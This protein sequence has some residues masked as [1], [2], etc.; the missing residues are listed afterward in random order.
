LEALNHGLQIVTTRYCGEVVKE[1]QSGVL[2]RDVSP[3]EIARAVTAYLENPERLA[4]ARQPTSAM[5]RFSLKSIGKQLLGIV[6]SLQSGDKS[7]SMG[8][9]SVR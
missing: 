3:Q 1:G 9:A 6:E 2:M 4:A 5:T 7:T 8:H